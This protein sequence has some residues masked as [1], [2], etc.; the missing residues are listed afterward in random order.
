MSQLT[1]EEIYTGLSKQELDKAAKLHIENNGGKVYT[2]KQLESFKKY[3][4]ME[5]NKKEVDKHH[6][7][8]MILERYETITENLTLQQHGLLLYLATCMSY[9][10]GGDLYTDR[11]TRVSAQELQLRLG[12]SKNQ[13]NKVL[14]ELEA[15]GVIVRIKE[16]KTTYV[17]MTEAVYICGKVEG[18][19]VKL[20][21]THLH[22]K[23]KQ[24]PLN[25][26][27]LF[28]LLLNHMNWKTNLVVE[29]PNEVDASKLIL[30]KRSHIVKLLG[31]SKP[32]V[33]K[34]MDE[35]NRARLI[36]EVKSITE[37]ICLDPKAV[38]RQAKKITFEELLDN[39]EK[40][41]LS[42]NNFKK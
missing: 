29:N 17:N 36:V 2:D 25:A 7:S 35:L 12:K 30:L 20:F 33:N 28:A 3:N 16:G 42:R 15:N 6:H 18:N 22:E 31:L 37:A 38:S 23:A 9:G 27:G 41:S 13:V 5:A 24:L 26:L 40:A 19:V 8:R 1:F 14:S 4:E 10:H 21:K 39:I 11:G 32:T 34:L